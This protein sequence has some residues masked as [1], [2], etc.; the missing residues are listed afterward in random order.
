MLMGEMKKIETA[1][2]SLRRGKHRSAWIKGKMD[3]FKGRRSSRTDMHVRT[4]GNAHSQTR[5][6]RR[7][8]GLTRGPRPVAGLAGVVQALLEQAQALPEAAEGGRR[9]SFQEQ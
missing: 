8:G 1:H 6:R 3:R 9:G 2:A 5:A 7:R 4:A